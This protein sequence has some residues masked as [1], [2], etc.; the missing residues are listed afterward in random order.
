MIRALFWSLIAGALSLSALGCASSAAVRAAGTGNLGD[1]RRAMVDE[2]RTG[3][4]DEAEVRAIA[5]A[6]ATGEIKRAAP[7]S[8]A[9]RL[10][11]LRTCARHLEDALSERASGNDLMAPVAGTILLDAGLVDAGSVKRRAAERSSSGS[12]ELV[13]AFRALQTQALVAGE[14]GSLRRKRMLDGDEQVRVAAMRA[15]IVSVDPSDR[16]VLLEAARLDP[17]PLARTLAIR[18]VGALGNE[19]VVLILKDLWVL[20]DEPLREAIVDAWA[21]RPSLDAGGRTQLLWAISSQRGAPAIAA[22]RALV[23]TGGAGASDATAVLARAIDDGIPRDRVYAILSAPLQDASVR[24]A[25]VRAQG[26]PD[27]AVSFAAFARFAEAP[28]AAVSARDR[29]AAVTWLLRLAAGSSPRASPARSSLARARVR[30]VSALLERDLQSKDDR[31]REAAGS[32]LVE[33]G[34]L[35]RAAMLLADAETRVRLS[36]ACAI[37][38]AP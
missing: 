30:A 33:L 24:A 17:Q 32:S 15:A 21:T 1:L 25:L 38:S 23:R 14:D 12:L 18:A 28:A 16:E 31:L 4:L 26:G 36:V 6:V 29:S 8:G 22:A 5:R 3:A 34:A 7:P 20:A 27:E 11:E 37:L 2:L 13:A 9:A 10:R 35:Q 19:A